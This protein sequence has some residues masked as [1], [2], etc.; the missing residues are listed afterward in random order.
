M[1]A[2]V[3]LLAFAELSGAQELRFVS[4]V[5]PG[6]FTV[7][8]GIVYEGAPASLTFDL[9]QPAKRTDSGL[10]PVLVIF[11]GYGISMMRTSPQSQGWAKAAS[12]HKLCAITMEAT[13]GH[14]AESL[15]SLISYL[16]R[17]SADLG[18]DPEQIAVI[19]W[20]GNVSSGLETVENPKRQ[21]I[22]AAVM[23]YGSGPFERARLDLPVLF[24]RAGLDQPDANHNLD[25]VLSAGLTANAPWSILNYPAGHHGFDVV[26]DN[27][28]S[29]EMVEE[30]FRF[31]HLVLSPS[32]QR[33]LRAGLPE[34]TAASAFSTGDFARAVTLY[35]PLVEAQPQNAHLLLAYGNALIGAKRYREARALFDSVKAIGS[36]GPRDLAL[37]AAR[38]S[39]LDGDP[40]AA[41]AWLRSIPRDIELPLSLE[42]DP[43]FATLKDR[44]DF[45]ALFHHP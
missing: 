42:T 21:A 17:H 43:A 44:A 37:P 45:Q 38:A 20:S 15:D 27:D 6:S 32:Y 36:A 22:K 5:P 9:F 28:A 29:R 13:Q 12:A 25:S 2:L 35:R 23:Y 7:R 31:L 14:V 40:D 41:I 8:S 4:P 3:M 30:T 34:A 18:I 39:A 1:K 11:N 16:G 24:V 10:L 26:D 33:A 19:A